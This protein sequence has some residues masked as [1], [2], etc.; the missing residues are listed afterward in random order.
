MSE[1][2]TIIGSK[3]QQLIDEINSKKVLLASRE[4]DLEV[5]LQR[6]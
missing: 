3:S 6:L 1:S 5:T 4:K 2:N